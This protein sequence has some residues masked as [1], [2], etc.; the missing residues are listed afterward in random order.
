MCNINTPKNIFL[1]IS[2]YVFSLPAIAHHSRIEY[3]GQIEITG[4]L[5]SILWRNPHPSF[6][7]EVSQND[8]LVNWMVEGWSSLN[9][10]D[11]SGITKAQFQEGDTLKIV[12]DVSLMSSHKSLD[13][14][15]LK[16]SL[17]SNK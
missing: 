11:R 16:P 15:Y 5:T 14:I 1:L 3:S 8:Q 9:T 17:R 6:T 7:I 10:F 13:A 4:K 2:L 12:L